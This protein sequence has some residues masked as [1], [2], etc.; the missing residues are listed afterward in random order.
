MGLFQFL[1]PQQQWIKNIKLPGYNALSDSAYWVWNLQLR[2]LRKNDS[3][4]TDD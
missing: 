1:N 4:M 2:I 3:Y